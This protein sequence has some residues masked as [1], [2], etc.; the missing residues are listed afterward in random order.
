MNRGKTLVQASH[1][2]PKFGIV[3]FP[4]HFQ[5]L[6]CHS[7]LKLTRGLTNPLHCSLNRKSHV[8]KMLHLAL[9]QDRNPAPQTGDG[10]HDHFKVAKWTFI[11]H[12]KGTP[13]GRHAPAP[14]SGAVRGR[15][16]EKLSRNSAPLRLCAFALRLFQYS[17]GRF[18]WGIER[19]VEI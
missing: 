5:P 18:Q 2:G 11:T 7:S 14:L 19:P 4:N 15:R 6:L 9:N 10:S 16:K 17:P 8:Q 13:R 1:P 12:P 3:F